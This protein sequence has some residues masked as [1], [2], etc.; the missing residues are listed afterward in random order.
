MALPE[1][2]ILDFEKVVNYPLQRYMTSFINFIKL[3]RLNILNYYSGRVA[4]ANTESFSN[5]TSLLEQT[6]LL[7]GVIEGNKGLMRNGKYWE[8]IETLTSMETSLETIENSSKWLRSAISKGNFSPQIE[9]DKVLK[10]FQTLEQLASSSGY[11]NREQDWVSI[12]LRNNIREED[13][14]SF[15]GNKLKVQGANK[16]FLQLNSVVDNISGEKVYGIDIDKKLTFESDDVKVLSYKDTVKQTV[17][18]LASLKKG[19][20]PEF[21]E[22]GIQSSLVVG[23]NKNNIAYPILFRQYYNTFGKDDTLK[24]LKVSKIDIIEDSLKIDFEVETRLGEVI[25]ETGNI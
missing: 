5:L 19:D 14:N 25:Q 21:P 12:S 7:N 13:Y 8:L 16:L 6:R 10:Q 24:S 15:G 11:T 17:K 18:V 1:K 3:D 23:A 20:T 2:I 22:D 9:V 4:N